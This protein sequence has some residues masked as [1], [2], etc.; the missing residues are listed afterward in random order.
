[1][2]FDA[3]V[4]PRREAV[5]RLLLVADALENP[6]PEITS[7]DQN[8]WRCGTSACALGHALVKYGQI[9]NLALSENQGLAHVE[10]VKEI[11]IEWSELG[12]TFGLTDDEAVRL[13]GAGSAYPPYKPTAASVAR[14]VRELHAQKVRELVTV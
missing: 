5:D 14:L 4:D 6:P 12:K 2:P 7:Y 3:S 1:M 11:A 13:F 8:H 9:G 10:G